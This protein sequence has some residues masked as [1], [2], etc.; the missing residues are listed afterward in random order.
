VAVEPTISPHALGISVGSGRGHPRGRR[1][2]DVQVGDQQPSAHVSEREHEHSRLLI[3][4]AGMEKN[5]RA[6]DRE[7]ENKWSRAAAL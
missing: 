5:D 1:P 4:S 3:S 6:K 7:D 2:H